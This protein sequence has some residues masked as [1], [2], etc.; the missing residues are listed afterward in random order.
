LDEDVKKLPI[1][2]FGE[3]DLTVGIKIGEITHRIPTKPAKTHVPFSSTSVV[4]FTPIS[5]LLNPPKL[6]DNPP[7]L[8][9]CIKTIK[10][11]IIEAIITNIPNKT[12]ISMVF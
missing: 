9:F 8:G 10:P 4:C 2:V 1:R 12:N 11:K 6:P 3:Y 7:P 5:W